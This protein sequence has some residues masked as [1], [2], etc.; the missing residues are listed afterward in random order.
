MLAFLVPF[1]APTFKLFRLQQPPTIK[2]RRLLSLDQ[3]DFDLTSNSEEEIDLP[4]SL[5]QKPQMPRQELDH[6]IV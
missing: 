5:S 2:K 3:P 6:P 1:N 4:E